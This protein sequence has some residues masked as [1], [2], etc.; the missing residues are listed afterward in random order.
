MASKRRI[1]FFIKAI[2]PHCILF[3]LLIFI[4]SCRQSPVPKP[5]GYFKIHLPQRGYQ[6]YNNPDCPFTFQFPTYSNIT[7]D[8]LYFDSKP[9]NDCW[10]NLNIPSLNGT[11]YIS[12]KDMNGK[13]DLGKLIDDTHKLTFRHTVKAD[14][15][16]ESDIDN[17]N[18][19]YGVLYDVG[20]D[21]ASAVQFFL[22]DSTS[23]FIRG[24]LYFNTV[25]NADS[26]APAVNFVKEDI[27]EMIKTFRW[28]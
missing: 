2:V 10:M 9:E 3:S 7:K 6:T 21:A 8:T 1:L 20:G 26:L 25:P 27:L 23:H 18:G 22:T 11:I 19:V 5:K 13:E 24:S 14:F 17:H 4:S 12:Y 28:K 16:D 15:I